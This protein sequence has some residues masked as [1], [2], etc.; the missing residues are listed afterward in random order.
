MNVKIISTGSK[1]NCA[2]IDDV[3][4]VD[5]GWNVR[6]DGLTVLLTHHHTDHVK[7]LDKMVGLPIY[8]MPETIDILKGMP[9]FT[10][11]PFT[12]LNVD[13]PTLIRAEDN[14]YYVSVVPLKHDV[15]CVGFDIARIN[16]LT[17]KT[18][19]IFFATDFN[20]IKNETGF[21][22]SLRD[23]HYDA[24]YI[25]AN[26]TLNPADFIEVFFQEDGESKPKN[27]FH[28]ERSFRTHA[29]VDYLIHLFTKAGYSETNRFTEPVTLLHKSSY[30]YPQN[31]ERIVELCKIA[32]IVNPIH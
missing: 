10:Y 1:G 6:P 26:N 4:I 11:M 29:N 16:L 17:T 21:I 5:A 14:D 2:T 12:P 28:R 31:P 22:R 9:R 30:Y 18:E 23:K 25:E 20:A 32:K 24:I 27:S 19:R 13:R 8:A 7:Y 15:P 3:L